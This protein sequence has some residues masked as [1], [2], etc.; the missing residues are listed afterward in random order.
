MK[1]QFFFD[2]E[3]A[4]HPALTRLLFIGLWCLAD[5]EGRLEDR[6]KY[7][8]AEVLP[9][10]DCE[11]EPMLTALHDSKF[12]FKYESGGRN[13]IQVVN[14]L[15][16]QRIS[17]K[18]AE[19]VSEFP[20]PDGEAI[21][22]HLGSNGEAPGKHPGAQEGKG[23]EGKEEGKG[24]SCAPPELGDADDPVFLIFPCK[25][26]GAKEW[27]LRESKLKQYIEAFPAVDVRSVTRHARQWCIDNP[28]K[29]KT[30]RGMPAF[31][32]RWFGRDQ[33][34]GG[35]RNAQGEKITV[36]AKPDKYTHLKTGGS[37]LPKMPEKIAIP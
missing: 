29:R 12:I 26:M 5:K 4:D 21:G 8:K 14:F 10:D 20:P 25:G 31:L 15:K 18:E 24:D 37:S 36:T 9:Y 17:G 6:P 19:G 22:K 27:K 35:S 30:E 33:N 32:T 13:Y 16:H 7:I 2:E 34:R 28:G 3:L 23:R 1:P 11:V